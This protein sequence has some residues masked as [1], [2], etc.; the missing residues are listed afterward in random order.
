VLQ[1]DGHAEAPLAQALLDAGEEIRRAYR[2]GQI[3]VS[4]DPDGVARENLVTVVDGREMEPDHVLEEHEDV[5]AVGIGKGDE[6]RERRL[7]GM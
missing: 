4:G 1:P 3:G 7:L 6:A 2:R 5:L